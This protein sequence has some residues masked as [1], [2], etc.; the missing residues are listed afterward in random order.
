M[1][2]KTYRLLP[3]LLLAAFFLTGLLAP[4]AEAHPMST[5]AVLL[6][7]GDDS[8]DG[9]IQLPWTVCPSRWTAT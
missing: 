3:A 9:E 4:T 8:V 2:K 5:S 7:I 1:T 6:D